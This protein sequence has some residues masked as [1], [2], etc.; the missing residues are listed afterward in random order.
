MQMPKK[1]APGKKKVANKKAVPA[2]VETA[3]VAKAA[4]VESKTVLCAEN[5]RTFA[6]NQVSPGKYAVVINDGTAIRQETIT[7]DQAKPLTVMVTQ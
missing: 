7:V 4:K 5:V 1:K 6:L 3:P 2:P